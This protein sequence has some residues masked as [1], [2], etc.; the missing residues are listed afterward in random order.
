[1]PAGQGLCGVRAVV[2]VVETAPPA[3]LL[4]PAHKGLDARTA[5]RIALGM[6]L[7]L[8]LF[9]AELPCDRW[10]VGVD[11]DISRHQAGRVG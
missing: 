4:E 8:V 7:L 10:R 9:G 1:M 3:M 5:V 11:Q 6:M 2:R